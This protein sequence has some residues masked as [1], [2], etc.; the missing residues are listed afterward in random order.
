MLNRR[1]F[2]KLS[3]V[4]S[5]LPLVGTGMWKE[6][7]SDPAM[8]SLHITTDFPNGGGE[9]VVE[10]SHP[11]TIRVTPHNQNN[12]GWSQLWWHFKVEGIV[13]G[14]KITLKIAQ[15][16]GRSEQIFYSYDDEQWAQSNAGTLIKE[17]EQ[18]ITLIHQ[19]VKSESVSF[20]Y[21]LP[22]RWKEI[23][24]LLLPAMREKPKVEILEFCQSKQGRLVPGIL[25]HPTGNQKY[26][27]WL[28]ARAHAFEAGSSWVLHEIALW[29]VSDHPLAKALRSEA[30][31]MLLPVI[32]V[33]AIEEG[34]TGKNQIPYDH[35]RGW[36]EAVSHWPEVNKIKSELKKRTAKGALDLFIDFHGPGNQQH[37]YFIVAKSQNLKTDTQRE[38]RQQFFKVLKALPMEAMP[39]NSQSMHRFYYSERDWHSQNHDSSNIWVG[40][41]TTDQVVNMTLEVNMGT[42]LSHREGFRQEAM[43]LGKAIATYFV[44]GGHKTGME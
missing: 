36:S 24:T 3:S 23:E 1:K 35:N 20:A 37:P 38:N 34:R 17:A 12:G 8:A 9:I 4:G 25:L 44:E 39:K 42:R 19:V 41:N 31:I 18:S 21:D 6:W 33:D 14:T 27:I 30:E 26:N 11:L 29:L 5:T 7:K 32:D 16:A 13:P 15:D 2:I 22:Y 10:K 40:Q 28:Q 43:V